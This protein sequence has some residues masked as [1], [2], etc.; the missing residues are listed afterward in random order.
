MFA[1]NL[2][3]PNS[4]LERLFDAFQALD[5]YTEMIPNEVL[6]EVLGGIHIQAADFGELAEFSES[7][8]HRNLIYEGTC[9]KALVLCWKSG[10]RSP[11][12]NHVG[13]N[14]FVRVVEGVATETV[15][16]KMPNGS[17]CPTATQHYPAGSVSSAY[18]TDTHVIG[19]YQPL[20]QDLITLHV[21]SPPL[22]GM[23]IFR[24]DETVLNKDENVIQASL[25]A[26]TPK[27]KQDWADN[28]PT[29]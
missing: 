22:Q 15:F 25:Q 16:E 11:I 1:L 9:F 23:E 27:T 14:C 12:H 24:L 2:D 4:N 6:D 19:N 10:Q 5:A 29:A 3:Q 20:D 28:S 21:Y 18:D 26:A 13:S 7:C 17:W 8:Y